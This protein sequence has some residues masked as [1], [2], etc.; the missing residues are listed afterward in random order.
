MRY[1]AVLKNLSI[2]RYLW[3]IRSKNYRRRDFGTALQSFPKVY[4]DPGLW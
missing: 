4:T 1:P 3:E 2:L